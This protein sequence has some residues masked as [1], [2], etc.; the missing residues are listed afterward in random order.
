M[1]TIERTVSVAA[2]VDLVVLPSRLA[3]LFERGFVPCFAE[4]TRRLGCACGG[5][6][7]CVDMDPI[8]AAMGDCDRWNPKSI[9][10][11]MENNKK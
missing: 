8:A 6:P 3:P 10:K 11:T 9:A 7:H 1:L 4:V 2:P 5:D